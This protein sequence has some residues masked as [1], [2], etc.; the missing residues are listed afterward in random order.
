[1]RRS[2]TASATAVLV[3]ACLIAFTALGGSAEEIP[4]KVPLK[5]EYHKESVSSGNFNELG[6][7]GWELVAV[8]SYPNGAVVAYFKRSL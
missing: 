6:K 3:A 4:K 8:T 7:D 5:W 2:V 1:M